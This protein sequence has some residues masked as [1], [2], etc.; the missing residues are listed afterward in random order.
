[1]LTPF[2][3]VCYNFLFV[4]QFIIIII[5]IIIVIII[6]NIV[7]II[8]IIIKSFKWKCHFTDFGQFFG[9]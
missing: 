3:S 7:V 4:I 8:V 1:M 6:V 5:I 9:K 2:V